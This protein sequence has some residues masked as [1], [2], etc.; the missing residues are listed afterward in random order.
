MIYITNDILIKAKCILIGKL[1]YDSLYLSMNTLIM[2]I[3]QIN[4]N[5][6]YYLLI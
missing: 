2:L 1:D 6:R 4:L 3:R 5:F